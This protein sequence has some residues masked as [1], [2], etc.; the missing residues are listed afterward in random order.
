MKR[1]VF[2]LFVLLLLTS[3]AQEEKLPLF[4]EYPYTLTGTLSYNGSCCA[5]SAVSDGKGECRINIESP[6]NL[7]GYSFKVDNSS[8]WVYYDNM[9]IELNT[10][11]TEIP[12][13]LLPIML[14]VSREDFEYSLDNSENT[15]YHFSKD[16]SAILVSVRRK[17]ELPCRVV[18]KKEGTVL[19]LDIESFIIQRGDINADIQ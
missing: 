10:G 9:E 11:R 3:C 5:I 17:E 18:Y 4:E 15:D 2:L 7:R 19:T 6:E 12:F 13:A 14:G 16:G 1:I 8:V